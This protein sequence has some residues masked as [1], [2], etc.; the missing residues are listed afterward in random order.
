MGARV[1]YRRLECLSTDLS[2]VKISLVFHF[3]VCCSVRRF[4][5]FV[6]QRNSVM[7]L[8]TVFELLLHSTPYALL[9]NTC[10]VFCSTSP[11]HKANDPSSSVAKLVL[12]LKWHT[13]SCNS[14]KFICSINGFHER[15]YGGAVWLHTYYGLL[16]R[17]VNWRQHGGLHAL[18][19]C[20]VENI[21]LRGSVFWQLA[22]FETRIIFRRFRKI[23]KCDY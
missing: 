11:K 10:L 15:I 23:A 20:K 2:S 8:R 13:R 22:T 21:Q 14:L 9:W 5:F 19:H 6:P 12:N 17:N 3:L 18:L 16:L 7:F 1:Y 4:F